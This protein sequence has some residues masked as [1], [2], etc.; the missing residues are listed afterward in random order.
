VQLQSTPKKPPW[1]RNPNI[2]IYI[3][4]LRSNKNCGT[5][6]EELAKGNFIGKT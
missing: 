2:Y 6:E 4:D 1:Q 3:Y 5:L